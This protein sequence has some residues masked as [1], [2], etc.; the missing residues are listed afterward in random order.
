MV[1]SYT[2]RPKRYPGEDTHIFMSTEDLKFIKNRVCETVVNGYTYFA[3]KIQML[4][5]DVYIVDPN[6]VYEIV[7]KFKNT[8]LKILYI[9]SKEEIR[10][11]RYKKRQNID[12]SDERFKAEDNAFSEFESKLSE[13]SSLPNISLIHLENNE[14]QYAFNKQLD[15]IDF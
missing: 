11:E 4:T 2:D 13:I 15:K 10:R 8:N 5:S 1:K 3:T 9:T 6:G 7:D 12:N 14:D